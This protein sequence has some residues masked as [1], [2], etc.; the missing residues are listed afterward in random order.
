MIY[1]LVG[2]DRYLLERELKRI[3]SEV[4]PDNLSTNRYDKS[5][6]LGEVSSAVATAGFFG[7][8]RVIVAE[9]VMARASGAGGS[10]TAGRAIASVEHV[11][12]AGSEAGAGSDSFDSSV[13]SVSTQAVNASSMARRMVFMIVVPSDQ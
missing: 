4:D 3:L 9:G 6:P 2:P 11:R 12:G 13:S 8:G 7:A 1:L 10:A 5:S